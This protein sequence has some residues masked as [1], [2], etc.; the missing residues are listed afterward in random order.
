MI[1]RPARLFLFVA[2]VLLGFHANAQIKSP[3]VGFLGVRS[4]AADAPVVEA[5]R[6]GLAE[7][8]FREG[9]NLRVEYRW[10]DGDAARL[11]TIASALVDLGVDAIVA[12]GNPAARSAKGATATIPIV[13]STGADPVRAGLVTSL[14]HPGGNATGV[15]TFAQ[16]LGAKHVQL[17]REIVP[18]AR[19]IALLV[20]PSAG[21]SES[22]TMAVHQAIKAT[23]HQLI[24]VNASREGELDVAFGNAIRHRAAAMIV[25]SNGLFNAR[26]KQIVAL[27]SGHALPTIYTRREFTLA[28]GLASYGASFSEMYRH[29]GIYTGKIL[30]G[31]SPT[32]LPVM[33]PTKFDLVINLKTARALA[34]NPSREILS[35]AD[36]VVE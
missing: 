14:N 8:G 35:I 21:D 15:T 7:T 5:F 13:F 2:A 30:K 26:V 28:G 33:Q 11:P 18:N 17:V 3:V 25:S 27:A 4:A 6:N 20:N 31:A 36:E 24:V 12:A 19:V 32:E 10:A 34:L 16:E 22:Q 23:G 1:V 9:Q 29:V